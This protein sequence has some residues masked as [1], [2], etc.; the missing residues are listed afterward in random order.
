M[1]KVIFTKDGIV[2]GKA[3]K[4]GEKLNVSESIF[5]DLKENQKCIKEN[6]EK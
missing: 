2:N 3:I 4:K 1:K 5:F 6:K